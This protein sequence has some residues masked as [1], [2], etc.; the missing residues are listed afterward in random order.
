MAKV[1]DIAKGIFIP[2]TTDGAGFGCTEEEARQ[3]ALT[4]A[5]QKFIDKF[6][7][8][9][10]ENGKRQAAYDTETWPGIASGIIDLIT[11]AVNKKQ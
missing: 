5:S 11:K 2:F 3:A 7:E 8:L 1:H 6:N 4:E 9:I 10:A